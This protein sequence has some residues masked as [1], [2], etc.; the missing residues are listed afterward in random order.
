M[1]TKHWPVA[2]EQ[3]SKGC[4]FVAEE[5]FRAVIFNFD[6]VI[7][8]C[9]RQL[10]TLL[11]V[12][13]DMKPTK[14]KSIFKCENN[15]KNFGK[16][17]L[18]STE[19]CCLFNRQMSTAFQ[20][21]TS[22]STLF[23]SFVVWAGFRLNFKFFRFIFLQ[24]F[25]SKT[26]KKWNIYFIACRKKLNALGRITRTKFGRTE[27]CRSIRTKS[28]RKHQIEVGDVVVVFES[29][30]S[31]VWRR[32][33]NEQKRSIERNRQGEFSSILFSL[34]FIAEFAVASGIRFT[35]FS[36]FVLRVLFASN[37]SQRTVVIPNSRLYFQ[38]MKK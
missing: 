18:E 31:A 1:E 28:I 4:L 21:A 29:I 11:F 23:F 35:Y 38:S 5:D 3:R 2:Q 32:S 14:R 24:Y 13:I 30:L 8:C 34:V 12:R 20:S 26:H 33:T 10:W 15:F 16:F 25:S 36:D 27:S 37:Q 19:K 7:C 22:I 9:T 6:H 17:N